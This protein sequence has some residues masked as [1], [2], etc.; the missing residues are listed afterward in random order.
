MNDKETNIG[1]AG[2]PASVPAGSMVDARARRLLAGTSDAPRR[3]GRASAGRPPG[4]DEIDDWAPP[5]L[6]G[7]FQTR[8]GASIVEEFVAGHDASDV[9]RELVQNEFD[10]GG[11]RVSVTFGATALTITG[12][13]SSIDASGWLRL[14]VI[15]GTGRVVGGE[16]GANVAA[17]QNGIGSKNFGLRSLFLFGDRIY[18]RSGGR[19]AV[20]DLPNLGTQNV[21]DLASRGQRGV[22]IHVSARNR[23]GT[24]DGA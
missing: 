8:I 15:L 13:G 21:T 10:A 14:G 5:H 16:A 7:E 6:K 1:P 19:M 22:S 3:P 4:L 18:V 17:K 2:S 11:N 24:S 20:L 9:L 23:A 12:N